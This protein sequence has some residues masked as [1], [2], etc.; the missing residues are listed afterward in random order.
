MLF[1][2]YK[3]SKKRGEIEIVL[4]FDDGV[5]ESSIEIPRFLSEKG[6]RA[7]FF[8]PPAKTKDRFIQEIVSL[9]HEVGGHGHNHSEE[10][11]EEHY[12]TAA[13]NC[14]DHLKEFYP[15]LV[16]WRFPG[17]R[18]DK[19]AYKNVKDAGFKIDSTKG[20]YFPIQKPREHEGL[21]EYP[22]TRLPPKGQMDIDT[23]SYESIQDYLSEKVS[24]WKGIMV[25]PFHTYY[26]E[27]NFE[28]FKNLIRELEERDLTFKR[29]IDVSSEFQN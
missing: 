4:T 27:D 18:T 22:F 11:A 6:I 26:Q 1:R 29:L 24:K 7:T 13:S 20:S 3:F 17:L 5:D 16:S 25:L 23:R 9:G 15:S 8:I 12:E 10:E 28:K 21:E 2:S 19:E 14:Y